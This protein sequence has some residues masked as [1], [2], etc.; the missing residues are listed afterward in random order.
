MTLSN[1]R[2]THLKMHQEYFV[3]QKLSVTQEVFE[4]ERRNTAQLS[5][6]QYNGYNEEFSDGRSN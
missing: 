2:E 3:S 4:E 1:I 5:K 6:I